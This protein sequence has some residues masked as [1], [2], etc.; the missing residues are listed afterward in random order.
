MTVLQIGNKFICNIATLSVN[1][2]FLHEQ[3]YAWF[4]SS[5]IMSKTAESVGYKNSIHIVALNLK[6]TCQFTC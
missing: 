2:Y 4:L 3:R 1:G 6:V 5:H